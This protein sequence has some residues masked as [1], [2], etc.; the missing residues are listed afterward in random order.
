M[1]NYLG[2]KGANQPAVVL[3][4]IAAGARRRGR[5]VRLRN[6]LACA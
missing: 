6:R 5:L 1:T 4:V 3:A 2:A